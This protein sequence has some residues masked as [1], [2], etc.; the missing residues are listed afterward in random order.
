MPRKVAAAVAAV[1][2]GLFGLGGLGMAGALP[3]PVQ[4]FVATVTEPLGVDMPRSDDSGRSDERKGT[5]PAG[6]EPGQ[7][8]GPARPRPDRLDPGPVR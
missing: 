5:D 3:G 7:G 2:V 8:P 1:A 4:D 6:T